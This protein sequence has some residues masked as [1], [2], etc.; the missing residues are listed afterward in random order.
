MTPSIALAEKV[1]ERTQ[2]KTDY[3][4]AKALGISQSNLAKILEGKRG[5]GNEA[6]FRAAEILGRDPKDIIAEVELHRAGPDKKT[7]WEKRLP[8]LLPAVAIWGIAAG[9]TQFTLVSP[10]K[11]AGSVSQ[12]I[13]YAYRRWLSIQRLASSS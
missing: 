9:V 10:A 1:R 7:F 11:A 12:A 13:H 5:F 6:C 8:R 2:T 3:A 4:V